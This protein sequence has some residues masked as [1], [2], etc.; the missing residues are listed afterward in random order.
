MKV[1]WLSKIRKFDKQTNLYSI[2]VVHCQNSTTLIFITQEAKSLGFSSFLVSDKIYIY[3]LTIP[4]DTKNLTFD[5]AM[6]NGKNFSLN[7]T[8]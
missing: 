1:K 6:A 8:K 7:E 3:Y 4:D 5:F 2:E